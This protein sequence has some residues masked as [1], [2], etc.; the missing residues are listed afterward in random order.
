MEPVL[1]H[2]CVEG[3]DLLLYPETTGHGD[4]F[5]NDRVRTLRS[6]TYSWGLLHPWHACGVSRPLRKGII[7][8]L[9]QG[10]GQGIP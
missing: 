8:C 5:M 1:T 7:T 9:H 4:Y 10:D 2:H 6:I 3:I